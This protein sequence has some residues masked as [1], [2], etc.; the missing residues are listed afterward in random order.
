VSWGHKPPY[1][2]RLSRVAAR[3]TLPTLGDL[4][5]ALDGSDAL[6]AGRP[7][8]RSCGSW[9]GSGES[10]GDGWDLAFLPFEGS[11][12]CAEPVRSFFPQAEDG[13][14]EFVRPVTEDVGDGQTEFFLDAIPFGV[15]FGLGEVPAI[16]GDSKESAGMH[17]VGHGFVEMSDSFEGRDWAL[18]HVR[19]GVPAHFVAED[20]AMRDT[21]VEEAERDGGV[22]GMDE[23]ALSLDE[24]DVV[25]LVLQDQSLGCSADEVGDDGVDGA[26]VAGDHDAGLAGG[27]EG[28][29]VSGVAESVCQLHTDE[30]LADVAVVADRVDSEAV[31]VDVFS[32]GDIPFLVASYIMELG[33]MHLGGLGDLRV[34]GE[35]LVQT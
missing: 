27:D 23:A 15:C 34:V 32:M 14:N 2:T 6:R 22:T 20:E 19:D 21:A 5:T 24:H 31:R 11:A 12:V 7:A 18:F 8:V 35:E 26:T 3:Q 10:T 16:H 4:P 13:F 9:A 25:V 28:G 30:H 29:I 17:D 33:A 1:G